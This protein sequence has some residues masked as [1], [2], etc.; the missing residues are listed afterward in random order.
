MPMEWT[1]VLAFCQSILSRLARVA[2]PLSPVLAD[3]LVP[4][5]LD[6]PVLPVHDDNFATIGTDFA[7]VRDVGMLGTL[8]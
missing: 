7:H 4:P 8:F 2:G 1:H 6:P 3:N 5:R